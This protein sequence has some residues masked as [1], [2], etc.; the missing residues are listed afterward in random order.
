V[1]DVPGDYYRRLAEIDDRHWWVRGMIELEAALIAPWL[2]RTPGAL[3]DAG[4]GTGGF[5]SW[6]DGRAVFK[7]LSGVDLS[8]EAIDVARGRVP[9]ADLR[10]APLSSLPFADGAFDVVALN[11]V[12]QHVDESETRATM[13]ELRR[14]LAEEGGLVVRTNGA[15]RG[16][17]E[18]SDWRVYDPA[19]LRAELAGGGFDVRR[20][21]FANMTFSAL[22]ELRGRRPQAPSGQTSGVPAP[23]GVAISKLGTMAL[24]VEAGVV[25]RGG[26]V[27]WGH[28]LLALAVPR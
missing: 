19:S 22:A 25:R 5:L 6:A 7:S 24:S 4:C 16:R 26:R 14:V 13:V 10:V 18:R 15:R 11:D 27:P 21:T 8:P 28:T 17:R 1:K 3:L 2:E 9:A 23:A 12:L 20:V